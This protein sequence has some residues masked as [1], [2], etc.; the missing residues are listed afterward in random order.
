MDEITFRFIL[1]LTSKENL[2][3]R[4]MNVVT[5]YL[6]GSLESENFMKISK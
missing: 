4:L 1:G 3:T 2:E 6:Y 5:A